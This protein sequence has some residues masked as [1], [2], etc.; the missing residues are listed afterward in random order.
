M[1]VITIALLLI[2][3]FCAPARAQ[4]TAEPLAV[5]FVGNSYTYFNNL[6]RLFAAYAKQQ[7]PERPEP[8][9][10]MLAEPAAALIDRVDDGGVARE[11]ARRHYDLVVLQERGG[12]LGC[13]T[14]VQR[15]I[16][17]E[18]SSTIRAHRA[19]TKLARSAGA[20]VVLLG[21]WTV[22]PGEQGPLSRGLRQVAARSGGAEAVDVGKAIEALKRQWR[23]P[24]LLHSDAHPA[25]M[26]S[27]LAAIALWRAYSR[28]EP[29]AA[30]FAASVPRYLS[31]ARFN[32]AH[33]ASRLQLAMNEQSLDVNLDADQV[34]MML[35]ALR[36]R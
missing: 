28:S 20:R 36:K 19:L 12:M 33:A 23:G 31:D 16:P 18:C 6:P 11:L 2:A 10:E 4:E 22:P 34:A 13:L 21:T 25:P 17:P 9:T 30:P 7:Q 29:A 35:V 1:R 8:V 5:L 24:P 3:A 27:A 14:T 15:P 26:G 32:A